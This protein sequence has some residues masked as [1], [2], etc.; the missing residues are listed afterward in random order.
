MAEMRSVE[1]S[2]AAI[3]DELN[4]ERAGVLGRCGRR[5]EAAISTCEALLGDVEAGDQHAIDAYRAARRAALQAI[6]DLCLQREVVG[7]FDH[8]WVHRTYRVPPQR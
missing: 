8:S 1:R 5:V 6:S 3:E 4:R 2:F 7:L